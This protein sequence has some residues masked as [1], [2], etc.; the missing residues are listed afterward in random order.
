[1]L[2]TKHQFF[3]TA[4][5]TCAWYGAKTDSKVKCKFQVLHRSIL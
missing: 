3:V 2:Q 4:N 5:V 1:M